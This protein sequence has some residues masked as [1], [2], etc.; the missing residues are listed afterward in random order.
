MYEMKKN[1]TVGVKRRGR[2][3]RSAVGD[4]EVSGKEKAE[5]GEERK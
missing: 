5:R 4:G 3:E 1:E 2:R